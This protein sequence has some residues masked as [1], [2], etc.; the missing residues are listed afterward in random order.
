MRGKLGLPMLE[1]K[2]EAD[3]KLHNGM[4]VIRNDAF[5]RQTMTSALSTPEQIL[6]I[7]Q[8]MAPSSPKK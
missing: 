4:I 1:P 5:N 8:R 3:Q 7:I 6:Q 2:K